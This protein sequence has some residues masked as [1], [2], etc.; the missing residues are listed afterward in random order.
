[1]LQELASENAVASTPGVSLKATR[2]EFVGRF[3]LVGAGNTLFGYGAYAL[4]TALLQPRY[5]HGYMAAG[6]MAH[7]IS[8]TFSFT[9][10]KWLVFKTHG[11]YLKEWARSVVV[12]SGGF[13]V[14]LIMLPIL[15]FGVH[16][17]TSL[18]TAAPYVAG[19]IMMGLNAIYYFIGHGR[20]TFR[21][22]FNPAAPNLSGKAAGKGE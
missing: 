19:A 13:V 14:T 8:V 1:M 22:G 2:P 4:L 16:H 7:L 6:V 21:T 17:L 15:V 3:L 9:T 20:F 12:Y 11:N 18:T 10:Y 5:A